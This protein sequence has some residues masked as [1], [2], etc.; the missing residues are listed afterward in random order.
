MLS[1]LACDSRE[2]NYNTSCYSNH[3]K[4]VDI[5]TKALIQMKHGEMWNMF[6]VMDTEFGREIVHKCVEFKSGWQHIGND[7]FRFV[8]IQKHLYGFCC[9]I[10]INSDGLYRRF[11]IKVLDVLGLSCSKEDL[12]F[13]PKKEYVLV[14]PPR[15]DL[16]Y[17]GLF[18][19]F[20][21][22]VFEFFGVE[23]VSLWVDKICGLVKDILDLKVCLKSVLHIWDVNSGFESLFDD[24]GLE[25]SEVMVY[26]QVIFLKKSLWKVWNK[27]KMK[28]YNG[29]TI[30]ICQV[31]TFKPQLV[32][33]RK[34][35]V[36]GELKE[37]LAAADYMPEGSSTNPNIRFD[38]SHRQARHRLR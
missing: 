23:D 9:R 2:G 16:H 28:A 19:E 32:S 4:H 38:S 14:V 8:F 18:V 30:R 34:E 35:S 24:D 36:P 6:F 13:V 29:S 21:Q 7:K 17:F 25:L 11:G 31:K 20:L 12:V 5:L 33:I 26:E 15:I 1:H 37:A 10:S 3:L 27:Y 22:W